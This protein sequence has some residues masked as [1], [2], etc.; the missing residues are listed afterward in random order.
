M[1]TLAI[2]IDVP[3]IGELEISGNGSSPTTAQMTEEKQARKKFLDLVS[4]YFE[5]LPER[6]PRRAG[7]VSRVE[8]LGRGTWSNFNHYL[9][10]A[11]VDI[12][13]SD[14][15]PGLL[16]LLPEG[17]K[18]SVVGDFELLQEWPEVEPE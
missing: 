1:P 13:E 12:G 11:T 4:P 17:S 16:K 7:N 2:T 14:I 10:L 18:V 8:L 5:S 9:L 3:P 6:P 15:A